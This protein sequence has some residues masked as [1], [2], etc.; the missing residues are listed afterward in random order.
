MA[1]IVSLPTARLEI[2]QSLSSTSIAAKERAA[3]GEDG[4]IWILARSQT[5]GYG[6]RGDAWQAG[7][8]D[9]MATRLFVLEGTDPPAAQISFVAAV[10]VGEAIVRLAPGAGVGLKWPNDVLVGGAKICGLLPELVTRDGAPPALC[11]GVGVNIVS[12]PDL[13]DRAAARLADIVDGPPP[14]PEAALEAIEDAFAAR[15]GQWRR[16]GFE[17]IRRAWSAAAFGVGRPARI[18]GAG[19]EIRGVVE[20][21]EP[22]GALRLRDGGRIVLARAGSLR[23]DPAA[24]EPPA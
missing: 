23:F 1:D 7:V 22:D 16:E 11:L 2:H 20:G 21:L 14:A 10:A 12:A 18:V 8:G 15:L 5:S 13:P 17:S 4:P 19:D 6:R 3:A 24:E 9:L